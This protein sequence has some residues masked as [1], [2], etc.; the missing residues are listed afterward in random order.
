MSLIN[1]ECCNPCLGNESPERSLELAA[2]RR[3]DSISEYDIVL[4]RPDL[5]PVY[6]VI[7]ARQQ[8][9]AALTAG[10]LGMGGQTAMIGTGL[11]G[12]MMDPYGQ[13]MLAIQQQ[14]LD[15]A[16]NG[17]L[18]DPG[19]IEAVQMRLL[20]QDQLMQGIQE[21]QAG[22]YGFYELIETLRNIVA[23]NEE[24]AMFMQQQQLQAM[25][26]MQVPGMMFDDPDGIQFVPEQGPRR[27]RGI[28]GRCRG[29][30]IDCSVISARQIRNY[31][32]AYPGDGNIPLGFTLGFNGWEPM[33]GPR[34]GY[35]PES[36]SGPSRP[37]PGGGI[38]LR[39]RPGGGL[40]GGLG[41]GAGSVSGGGSVLG[42][43]LV[44][45]GDMG[46][47]EAYGPLVDPLASPRRP[48]SVHTINTQLSGQ[49][50]GGVILRPLGGLDRL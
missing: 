17:L 27:C 2:R 12:M 29:S 14:Q 6:A 48:G 30:C 25:G 26:G 8:E 34:V 22:M 3:Q 44:P 4:N 13:D 23:E 45:L 21:V 39:P 40:G 20:G 5:N 10:Q 38:P 9:Y 33:D 49:G 15:L 37:R 35:P 19:I 46:P 47:D 42:G 50:H 11:E 41:S 43:G 32:G 28:P 7:Q 24:M 16:L 1:I 31:D 36:E 18:S